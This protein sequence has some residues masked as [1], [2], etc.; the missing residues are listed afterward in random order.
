MGV[1]T[2][3][4]VTLAS[5]FEPHVLVVARFSLSSMSQRLLLSNFDTLCLGPTLSR[6]SPVFLGLVIMKGTR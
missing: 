2:P 4:L 5:H 3:G 6:V 1:R